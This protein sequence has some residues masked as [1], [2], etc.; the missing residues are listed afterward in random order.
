MDLAPAQPPFER[1][2]GFVHCVEVA[3]VLG[4]RGARRV[5]FRGREDVEPGPRRHEGMDPCQVRAELARERRTVGHQRC[6]ARDAAARGD[7]CDAA[8]DEE[9]ATD[10]VTVEAEEQRLRR[11]HA[12]GVDGAEHRE[13]LRPRKTRRD[14]RRRIGA[15]HQ[16]VVTGVRAAGDVDVQREIALDRATRQPLVAADPDLVGLHRACEP[17]RDCRRRGGIGRGHLG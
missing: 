10:D 13:F 16:R 3:A 2:V 9:L 11:Q 4:N 5:A 15:Q 1:R 14:A 8:H 7:A 17:V 6:V 12:G